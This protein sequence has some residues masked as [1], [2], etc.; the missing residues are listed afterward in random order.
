MNFLVQLSIK[1]NA[2]IHKFSKRCQSKPVLT[3]MGVIRIMHLKKNLQKRG[4]ILRTELIEIKQLFFFFFNSSKSDKKQNQRKF[5]SQFHHITC[6]Y[7]RI[8]TQDLENFSFVY[9]TVHDNCLAQM[10]LRFFSSCA[11]FFKPLPFSA[12]LY[13]I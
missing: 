5:T 3:K 7:A 6:L 9:T 12:K 11:G 4:D 8:Q 10:R 2:K 13:V 1:T